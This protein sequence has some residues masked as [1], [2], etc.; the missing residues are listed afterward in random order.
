MVLLALSGCTGSVAGSL[1]GA[2]PA[3]PGC[4]PVGYDE[5]RGTAPTYGPR[6]LGRFLNDQH[7]CAGVWAGGVDRWMVP[8]GMV[9]SGS[10]AYLAGFDGTKPPRERYCSIERID[11]RSG[12]VQAR[13]DLVSGSIGGRPPIACR[14][15]GGVVV[16]EHG[17]W[18]AETIRLWLLDPDTLEV[19]RGWR[20]DPPLRGSF[21]LHDP[22]GRL[23]LGRFTTRAPG[24][25]DWFDP[26]TLLAPG[27]E[28]IGAADVVS[29]DPAPRG[30]QG[31]MWAALDDG[32]S[33]LWFV[34]STSACGVLVGPRGQRRAFIPGA[35]SMSL[36]ARG[37]LWVSS[38]SGARL[39]QQD[40]RPM[41]PQIARFDVSGLRGWARPDCRV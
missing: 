1:G 38:E 20:L 22:A 6:E 29:S 16:D 41:T 5:V 24:R 17:V 31:G 14:H 33:G 12:R 13:V 39:Y 25:V 3:E 32:E 34:R 2:P 10:T 4:G 9:V 30:T 37:R 23:G 27:T 21:A 36:D 28:S 35:E 40:G 8:Q 15:G 18:L 7:L 19:R 26:S 11:L